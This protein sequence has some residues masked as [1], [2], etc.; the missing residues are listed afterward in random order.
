MGHQQPPPPPTQVIIGVM[1]YDDG[2]VRPV[3]KL[4]RIYAV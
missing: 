3:I 4:L 2:D 1:S